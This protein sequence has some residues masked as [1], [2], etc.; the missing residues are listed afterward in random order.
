MG[1]NTETD[2]IQTK[3][4]LMVELTAQK[5]IEELEKLPNRPMKYEE[6]A[7]IEA[8]YSDRNDNCEA[9]IINLFEF[10]NSETIVSMGGDQLDSPESVMTFALFT[11]DSWIPFE[12]GER[13]WH[14]KE[15]IPH[16]DGVD[17]DEELQMGLMKRLSTL[18]KEAD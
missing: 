7:G 4:D 13:L 2:E 6:L 17:L 12:F 14:R 10:G 11:D 18:L 1:Y 15:S 9:W 8:A 16:P 3:Y 5:K